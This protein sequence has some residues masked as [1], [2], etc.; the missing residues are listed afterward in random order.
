MKALICH[1]HPEDPGGVAAYYRNLENKFTRPVGHFTVGRRPSEK[2]LGSKAFRIIHDYIRFIGVLKKDRIALVHF[3]PSLDMKS[4]LRDAV[5]IVLARL[6]GKRTVVFIRGWHKAFENILE[7]YGLWL[8]KLLFAQ[9]DALIVLSEEFKKKHRAWGFKHPIYREVTVADDDVLEGFDIRNAIF[10][11]QASVQWRILFISRILKEKG[12]YETIEAASILESKYPGILFIIA[13][14]GA[15]L[16][17]VK[18]YV[19]RRLI[20]NVMFT[21]YVKGEEKARLFK[22]AHILCFPSFHGEGL[23]HTIIESMGFGLPIVTRLVGGTADF[24]RDGVHGFSTASKKPED[25]AKMIEKLYLDKALYRKISNNNYRYAQENFMAS[26]AALRLERIY[27]HA[28][29]IL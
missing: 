9:I 22:K 17:R 19:K 16:D 29:R 6:L 23:P 21:G 11:R 7:R 2:G 8:Y 24:F 13:G 10:E 28:I 27:R 20:S 12:I 18:S 14:D 4:F 26:R 5:F 15:E 25:F 3:N 1:P